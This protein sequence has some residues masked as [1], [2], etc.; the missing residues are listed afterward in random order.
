MQRAG[1]AGLGS[2]AVLWLLALASLVGLWSGRIVEPGA[3]GPRLPKEQPELGFGGIEAAP[4][5]T[6]RFLRP[7]SQGAQ[8]TFRA[9]L[10]LPGQPTEPQEGPG[11]SG[12]EPPSPPPLSLDHSLREKQGAK[13]S[14]EQLPASPVRGGVFWSRALEAQVPAGFSAEE[15]ASWLRAAR[16]GR[17]VSL[18][19][20]GCGRSSNRLARLSDGSRACVR[21]GINP[22]QIQGEALSYHLAELL[23]IQERLPPLALARVEAR[24]GQWAQVRDE[25][26]GSH[27]AEGAVVS[28]AQWVDNLTDVVAPA[29]WRAEAGAAAGRRL[30][31]LTAG[32]L[33]GLGQAQL[34][35]L[36][37]WSDLILFDY[38]TANFDRLVSNLFSLQ[39]DPRVMHRATSNLHRAPN[40]G[41]V[42][43][44]NEAGLVHGYRLLAM[45]DKYNEPLLR[46][47]CIFREATAQ[48]VR[49]LYRLRNAAS[50]LLRLYRTREPLAEIVGFLS[51]RQAQLLQDRVDFVHKHILHCKAK[52]GA[53]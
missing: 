29:P 37:Q 8:K 42:F 26:R 22:E 44:D 50:E 39:W 5:A 38:L 32:E 20:G 24:G 7:P 16:E 21:Y 35:E 27:W 13:G 2:V 17:V 41:L 23:G 30:Q 52:A 6:S 45:W 49:E 51:D 1:L 19:R 40:G 10:T 3:F 18:E 12:Q 31:P 33:R 43:L 25:L 53:L 14:T 36:V 11:E 9:L 15:T 28:L 47:V 34:V 46:S 4:A 48:R